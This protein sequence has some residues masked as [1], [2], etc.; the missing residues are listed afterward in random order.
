MSEYWVD[1]PKVEMAR[2]DTWHTLSM[3]QLLEVKQQLLDKM[4]MA[5]GKALYVKPLQMAMQRLEVLIHQKMN[6]P[7]GAS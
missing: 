5:Q 1:Q 7:R 4:Y 2:P 3:N 6:D